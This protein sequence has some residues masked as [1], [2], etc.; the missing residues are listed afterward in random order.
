MGS[1]PGLKRPGPDVDHLPPFDAEVKERVELH[2]Y[3][4]FEPSWPVLGKTVLF[5]VLETLRKPKFTEVEIYPSLY[6]RHTSLVCVRFYNGVV[7]V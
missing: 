3:S 7:N 4:P 2:L 5:A 1:L 6:T